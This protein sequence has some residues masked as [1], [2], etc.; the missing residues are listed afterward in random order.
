MRWIW[1]IFLTGC[2]RQN[3]EPEMKIFHSIIASTISLQSLVN[4]MD[5]WSDGTIVGSQ[6]TDKSGNGR[7]GTVTTNLVSDGGAEF[8]LT[9]TQLGGTA[10]TQA[11]QY[12]EARPGSSGS[13][14]FRI[15]FDAVAAFGLVR[16]EQFV[17]VSGETLN[18]SFWAKKQTATSITW[19]IRDGRGATL[20]SG[21]FNALTVGVWTNVTGSVAVTAGKEGGL[22]SFL[23]NT[24]A[25]THEVL[26]D[27][28]EISVNGSS[29]NCFYLPD[30]ATLKATDTK[31]HFY[32]SAGIPLTTRGDYQYNA[33]IKK[34]YC[35]GPLSYIFLNTNPSISTDYAIA[36]QFEDLDHAFDSCPLVLTVGSA[37]TYST[38]Q[39]AISASTGNAD[40]RHRRRIEVY[41]NLS[42]STYAEFTVVSGGGFMAYIQMNKAFDYITSVGGQKTLT[43]TKEVT[44]NDT[45]LASTEVW[46]PVYSGGIRGITTTKSN[47]G[48]VW[49]QDFTGMVD[50]HLIIKD[51]VFTESGAQSVFDYRTSQGQPQ[52]AGQLSFNT[53]AGGLHDGFVCV[54]SLTTLTGMRPMTWQDA[55][56][57]TGANYYIRNCTLSSVA[58]YDPVSNPTSEIK[59]NMRLTSSGVGNS[60][61]FVEKGTNPTTL[62]SGA[63]E[64]IFLT[65]Y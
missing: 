48:Y 50:S 38:I 29:N 14:C 60:T 12:A 7:H 53:H 64:S 32:N 22:A 2:T 36:T 46:A 9:W 10:P 59:E 40:F 45:Q 33:L 24:G 35:G 44:L 56:V 41:D 19:V 28:I 52:P 55:Q 1:V 49:H 25:G 39:A 5:F 37:Q 61:V 57:T 17:V 63:I 42:V 18:Y 34:I 21:N 47:G 51:C 54:M 58:I 65:T 31:Y 43:A 3:I 26:L 4:Q 27:D 62:K 30:N 23:I 13:Y 15:R 6:L 11:G 16:T 20:T 8:G